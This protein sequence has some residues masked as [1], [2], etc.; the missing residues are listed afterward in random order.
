[1]EYQLVRVLHAEVDPVRIVQGLPRN[2]LAIDERT[3]A[4]GGIFDHIRAV[5]QDDTGMRARSAAIPQDEM[6]FRLAPDREWQRCNGN[7]AAVPTRSDDYQRCRT[8]TGRNQCRRF[9]R[10]MACQ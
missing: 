8:R 2:L 3:V 10:L 5:L 7:P 1:M 4:A 6:V 9:H